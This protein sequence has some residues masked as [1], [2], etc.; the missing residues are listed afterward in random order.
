MILEKRGSNL[1]KTNDR[2][3]K[4]FDKYG[5]MTFYKLKKCKD[6]IPVYNYDWVLHNVS[7]NTNILEK[8]INLLQGNNGTIFLF[9]YGSKQYKPLNLKTGSKMNRKLIQVNNNKQEPIFSYQ[10]IPFDLRNNFGTIDFEVIDW[11]NMNFMIQEQRASIVR[12]AKKGEYWKQ[13]L[14]PLAIIAGS[15]MVSLFIL[16]FSFDASHEIRGTQPATESSKDS[17]GGSKVGGVINNAF[18]PGE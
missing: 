4:F 10:Y 9:K 5:D 12:R 13:T 14:I 8:I 18:N 17:V 6:T 2:V 3:G 15:V 1:I 11:D 16:K 7:V